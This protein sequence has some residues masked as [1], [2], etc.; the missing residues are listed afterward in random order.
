MNLR[1]VHQ[2]GIVSR[3]KASTRPPT[4]CR[5]LATIMPC[6]RNSDLTWAS[7]HDLNTPRLVLQDVPNAPQLTAAA[8]AATALPPISGGDTN[9]ILNQTQPTPCIESAYTLRAYARGQVTAPHPTQA[10]HHPLFIFMRESKHISS[11]PC[12]QRMSSLHR[13]SALTPRFLPRASCT[14]PHAYS[15]SVAQ[16]NKKQTSI[17]PSILTGSRTT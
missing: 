1:A 14:V 13:F 2:S 3:R 6:R 10:K 8:S 9:L 4:L 15:R 12:N 11:R 16:E 7:C 17:H 5:I